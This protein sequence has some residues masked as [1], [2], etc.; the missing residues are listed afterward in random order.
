MPEKS[1]FFSTIKN[2]TEGDI[3]KVFRSYGWTVRKSS[4]NELN[5]VNSWTELVLESNNQDLLL[6]G[7]VAI[8]HDNIKIITDIFDSLQCVYQFE[9]YD[10]NK[11]I[12]DIKKGM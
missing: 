8:Y 12:K 4:S 1:N 7:L 9:L 2:K 6:H 3:I 11:I 5:L 10:N